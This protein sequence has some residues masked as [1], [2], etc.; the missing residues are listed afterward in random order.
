[1]SKFRLIQKAS[2]Q[3]KTTFHIINSSGDVVGSVNVPPKE[4]SDLLRC[5]NGQREGS[6]KQQASQNPI[7][8]AMLKVKPHA[9]SRAA[10]MRGCA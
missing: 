8:A 7:A 2:N 1:M 3:A 10:L 6:A 4:V 9:M 5:W